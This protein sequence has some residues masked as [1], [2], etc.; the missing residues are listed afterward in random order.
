[1]VADQAPM[2]DVEVTVRI[3]KKVSEWIAEASPNDPSVEATIA[4]LA[5][6]ADEADGVPLW[7]TFQ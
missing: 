1:M 5:R 2:E 3:P 4:E 7:G 6:S